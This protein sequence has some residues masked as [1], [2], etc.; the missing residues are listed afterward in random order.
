MKVLTNKIERDEAQRRLCELLDA[1]DEWFCAEQKG[2][3]CVSVQRGGWA[4]ETARGS[5]HFSCWSDAGL[6][7]WRVIAWEW[8]GERLRLE[9]TSR[10]GAKRATLELVPRASISAARIEIFAARRA[11]C[12]ELAR[13]AC[14]LVGDAKIER[15]GLSVGAR[16][17]E[18]G[19]YARILLKRGGALI[20][21]TGPV[22][23]LGAHE[24]DALLASSLM[25]CERLKERERKAKVQNLWIV[26]SGELCAA[27]CERLA[28]LR[29]NVRREIEL[30]E[31]EEESAQL[32][33]VEV[34]A[35]NHLLGAT[36]HFRRRA[37]ANLSEQAARIVALA[38]SEIDVVRARHG[39]TLRYRGLAFA[40]V[41]SV[42]Q[43]EHVWYGVASKQRLMGE[44]N[45][46]ELVKLVSEL[47]V[48][49]C[50]EA[51]DHRHALYAAAPEAWLESLLRRDITQL[52]PG[53]IV[54]PL[55]AQ[56]RTAR[57]GRNGGG[58]GARPVDLLALRRDGR[59]VVI[60][61]KVTEDAAL[62]L[63]GADYWRRVEAQRRAG[64]LRESHLFGAAKIADEP[65][66]VYLVAPVFRFHRS[67][68]TLTRCIASDIE[69]YRFDLNEDW[70]AGVRVVRRT[71]PN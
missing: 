25:W 4:F 46:T 27:M 23:E 44:S 32:T 68:Q 60:E 15:V 50:A 65:P 6:R 10:M 7:V 19:R 1:R 18:P 56:F 53:L 43:R 71:K 9:A 63:Q 36:T 14:R 34:P 37:Q 35:L 48:H 59:L 45:W 5:L 13:S 54:S 67:F 39:E 40:R 17:T 47:A 29:E 30:W 41:R 22:V 24:A 69:M 49:R 64:T 66:L 26:A 70:R 31:R 55:Y 38:P 58:T 8:T 20:A 57:E 61:L 11:L 16:R 33:R 21:V 28:L 2:R 52:D 3:A 51:E 12:E 62:P 42:L